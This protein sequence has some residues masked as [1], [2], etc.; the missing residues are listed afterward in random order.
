MRC[1]W[2]IGRTGGS[3]GNAVMAPETRRRRHGSWVTNER[4][5]SARVHEPPLRWADRGP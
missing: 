5:T 2:A 3:D 1:L 4:T